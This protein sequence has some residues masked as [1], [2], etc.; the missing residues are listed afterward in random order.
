MDHSHDKTGRWEGAAGDP[1]EKAVC[2]E[3][4]WEQ[5]GFSRRIK[6]DEASW[7]HLERRSADGTIYRRCIAAIYRVRCRLLGLY[8]R[9]T[10]R[11]QE[12]P[13]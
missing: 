13:G 10:G 7:A 8:K 4:S 6:L 12:A 3:R 5:E 11:L 9:A 2:W 1:Y